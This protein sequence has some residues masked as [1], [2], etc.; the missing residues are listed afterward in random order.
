[1]SKLI[2]YMSLR[3]LEKFLKQKDEEISEKNPLKKKKK[4]VTCC[5]KLKKWPQLST[6][7][8]TRAFCNVFYSSSHQEVGSTFP[9][10][11]SDLVL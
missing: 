2:F 10:L 3:C 9:S 7:P 8:S 5:G 6:P 1:M 11:E 4:L